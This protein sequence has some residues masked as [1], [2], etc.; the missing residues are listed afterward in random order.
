[1]LLLKYNITVAGLQII[2]AIAIRL[3][4]YFM[5]LVGKIAILEVLHPNVNSQIRA[6]HLTRQLAQPTRTWLATTQF[7][8]SSGRTQVLSSKTRHRRFDFGS[9]SSKPVQLDPPEERITSCDFKLFDE[10][11]STIWQISATKTPDS[12][13][14]DTIWGE[15]HRIWRN[16]CQIR[17]DRIGSWTDSERSRR[18]FTF[19][20]LSGE[21][22]GLTRNRRSPDG[23]PTRKTRP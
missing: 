12:T 2:V 22:F 3:E 9:L 1:M 8:S 15:K 10:F 4:L 13:I 11:S 5:D 7:D 16:F 17:L 6:V 18:F 14:L 20:V 19:F 23:K 21:S